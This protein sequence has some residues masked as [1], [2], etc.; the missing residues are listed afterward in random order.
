M[1]PHIERLEKERKKAEKILRD[2][3]Y[4]HAV[5]TSTYTV[6]VENADGC[7]IKITPMK[8]KYIPETWAFKRWI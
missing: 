1:E 6:P 2:V 7:K 4:Q 8:R 3:T 5:L